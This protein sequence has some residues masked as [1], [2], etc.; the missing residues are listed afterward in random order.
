MLCWRNAFH[1]QIADLGLTSNRFASSEVAH[2]NKVDPIRFKKLNQQDF[3]NTEMKFCRILQQST[4]ICN[5]IAK[6]RDNFQNTLN[7]QPFA[8]KSE[9]FCSFLFSA[10]QE[11]QQQVWLNLTTPADLLSTLSSRCKKYIIWWS[12]CTDDYL[13]WIL[14]CAQGGSSALQSRE[15][16]S[17]GGCHRLHC[18][19]PFFPQAKNV[20]SFF[21]SKSV[22]WLYSSQERYPTLLLIY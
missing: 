15:C 5:I 14:Q 6:Y 17:A 1:G 13:H 20:T 3:S 16:G 2:K 12:L 11:A 4:S 7:E 19:L 10:T 18:I 22:C 8:L 21:S 9:S